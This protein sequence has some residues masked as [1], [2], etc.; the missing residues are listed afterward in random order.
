MRRLAWLAVVAAAMAQDEPYRVRAKFER[1][2]DIEEV[3][4]R[5]DASRDIWIGERDFEAIHT[6]LDELA[7]KLRKGEASFPALDELARRF[8]SLTIVEIK[9]VSSERADARESRARL[10]LRIELAGA[11]REG[12]LL[13]IL[14]SWDSTWALSPGGWSLERLSPGLLAETRRP[15]PQFRDIAAEALG[16]SGSFRDHLRYGVDHWRTILDEATGIDVYGHHG[17][18]VADTDGDGLE[19]IYVCQPSGLPNRLY[20]SNGNGR[21]TDVSAASG[22]D[23]LDDTRTALFADFDNDGDQDVVAVTASQPL[24]FRNDGRGKYRYDPGSGLRIPESAAASLTGAA[25]A[26]YDRDGWLDLYVAA[27]D[28]WQPGR[29]YDAPAPYYDATNGPPNFLFRNRG[30]GIFEEATRQAGMTAGNDRYSFAAAWGDYDGDGDPDLYVANDFGRN[31][32]YRNNGNGT[33]TDVAREAG[34]EDLGAGMSAAWGDYDGDGRLDLYVGNMWSSA[35]LRLT[36]NRQLVAAAPSEAVRDA[37]RRHARGNSLYRNNGDGTFSDVT[38][39]AGVGMGR[40]AWASDFVDIDNDGRLD[41]FI[42]NGYITGPDTH[43]L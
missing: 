14:G 35:G 6:R 29:R 11:G 16:Q 28:F 36:S 9:V 27:Y 32:L 22:L 1:P 25:V 43:D 40:W 5:V 2:L 21:F 42:Q 23:L 4:R 41:L 20:R 13:S 33:F 19:D 39:R 30:R 38:G 24:L 17:I 3:L 26:D 37:L 15:R 10:T 12:G 34:V 31:N 7:A 18:A 8:T